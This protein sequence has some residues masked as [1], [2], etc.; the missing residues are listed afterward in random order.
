MIPKSATKKLVAI[1]RRSS[2]K[3]FEKINQNQPENLAVLR[4]S[5]EMEEDREY[6]NRATVL[7]MRGANRIQNEV[8]QRITS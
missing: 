6:I 8:R 3:K 7:W 2:N 1:F 5:E 4:Q